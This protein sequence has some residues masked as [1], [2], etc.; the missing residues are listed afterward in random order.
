MSRLAVHCAGDAV[1][2]GA[3][4]RDRIS[5]TRMAPGRHRSDARQKLPNYLQRAQGCQRA[6]Y[7]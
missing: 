4:R 7:S 6:L 1:Q 2:V 3:I 5:T